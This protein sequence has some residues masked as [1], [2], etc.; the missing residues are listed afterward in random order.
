[1]ELVYDQMETI[2][3]AVARQPVARLVEDRALKA[4]HQHDIQHAVVRDQDIRRVLVHVPPGPHFGALRVLEVGEDLVA[5]RSSRRKPCPIP[6]A[7]HVLHAPLQLLALGRVGFRTGNR[8]RASVATKPEAV[9]VALRR[10]PRAA[11]GA[12]ACSA[13]SPELVLDESVERIEKD[14][15][16]CLCPARIVCALRDALL[17][18][19]VPP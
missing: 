1:M 13:D 17:I 9:A 3:C 10:K 7:F 16:E 19:I 5:A 14:R 18:A 15:T 11:I 4:A 12:V 8:R 6:L 2:P